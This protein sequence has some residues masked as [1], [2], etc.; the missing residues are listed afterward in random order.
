MTIAAIILAAGQ[1]SRMRSS[2]PKPLHEIG[3]LP[4]LHHSLNAAKK[5]GA[6]TF[7][8]VVGHQG[9]RVSESAQDWAATHECRLDIVW[10][11]EQNGTGH[12]VLCAKP[13]L[14]GHGGPVLVLFADSPLLRGQTLSDMIE[15]MPTNGGALLAFETPTPKGYG[16]IK[17][18]DGRVSAIVEEKDADDATRA[19]TK[20]NAGPIVCH[21]GM[22]FRALEETTPSAITGELYLT[23]LP[24]KIKMVAHTGLPEEALGVNDRIQLALAERAF[25]HTKRREVMLGGVT[26]ID[27]DSVTF[28][29]DTKIA[30]DVII[31][32]GVFFGPGVV[33][34]EGVRILAHSHITGAHIGENAQIGPFA[35]LRPGTILGANT[36]VGN[37]VET[38]NALLHD[39]AKASH[40]TYLGDATVGENANIGAGTITCNYDGKHKHQTAIGAD[41]FI[42]SNSALVAPITIG[43]GALVAAGSTVTENVPDNAKAFGRARQVNK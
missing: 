18:Q 12:A 27:P 17:E 25:Q 26:L 43:K 4:M 2:H 20:V 39:G 11:E 7:V 6:E 10:Q 23:S 36:K 41:A 5:A 35:R 29:H 9:D 33:V 38:K 14:K 13:A 22:L 37:F 24:E 8:V 28:A 3:S 19:I 30:N 32:P 40:L 1:G 16:R 15:A 42:G 21:G 31:E 34:E